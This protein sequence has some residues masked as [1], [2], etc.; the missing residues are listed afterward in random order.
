MF[1]KV[2]SIPIPQ[3]TQ[4][5]YHEKNDIR[6][7]IEDFIDSGYE[8]AEL[9]A[10]SYANARSCAVSFAKAA[11]ECDYPV[12]ILRRDCQVFIRRKYTV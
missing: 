5:R 8:A 9:D 10:S 6:A 1:R 2:D 11:S 3:R 4:E 7:V 12:S